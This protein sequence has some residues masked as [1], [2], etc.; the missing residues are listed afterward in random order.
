[1]LPV[2]VVHGLRVTRVLK[3]LLLVLTKLVPLTLELVCKGVLI[4]LVLV[5]YSLMPHKIIL[6]L[7]LRSSVTHEALRIPL[8]VHVSS[9]PNILVCIV[10]LK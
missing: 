1:M 8:V 5:V 7:L 2:L 4:V 3:M 10:A 9:V 6:S